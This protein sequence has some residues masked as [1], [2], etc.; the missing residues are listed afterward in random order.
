MPKVDLASELK[1]FR[2]ERE[3]RVG[4]IRRPGPRLALVHGGSSTPATVPALTPIE[5][6]GELEAL[7][8]DYFACTQEGRRHLAAVARTAAGREE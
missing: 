6:A 5:A 8:S 3:L 4:R 1:N 7:I 2:R